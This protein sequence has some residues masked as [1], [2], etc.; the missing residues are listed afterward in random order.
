MASG[1]WRSTARLFWVFFPLQVE[2]GQ[3]CQTGGNE[4]AQESASQKQIS[5]EKARRRQQNP[6]SHKARRR[7]EDVGLQQGALQPVQAR[8]ADK[9]PQQ[10]RVWPV[11]QAVLDNLHPP[12]QLFA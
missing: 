6:D 2:M 1:I 8:G 12:L 9:N 10:E 3:N 5:E 11:L 7:D 4:Q